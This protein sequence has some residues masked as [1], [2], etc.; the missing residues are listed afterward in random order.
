MLDKNR[1][2]EYNIAGKHILKQRYEYGWHVFPMRDFK[3]RIEGWAVAMK[4]F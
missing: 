1:L 4:L 3:F 2:L